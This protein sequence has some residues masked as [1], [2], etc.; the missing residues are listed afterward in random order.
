MVL[1]LAS[2]R[3]IFAG[4]IVFAAGCGFAFAD[5]TMR[6]VALRKSLPTRISI[7]RSPGT[8]ACVI[9]SF[10]VTLLASALLLAEPATTPAYPLGGL[11]FAVVVVVLLWRLGRRP[12]LGRAARTAPAAPDR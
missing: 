4:A 12:W 8:S 10:A 1:F 3:P 5:R 11:V 7:C 6:G 2:G 9:G